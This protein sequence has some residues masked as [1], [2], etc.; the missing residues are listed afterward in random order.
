MID[1]MKKTDT[2]V[3]AYAEPAAGPGWANS[4]VW[5][6]VRDERHV[7]REVCL[8]PQDQSREMRLF[9]SMSSNVNGM[10]VKFVEDLR[11]EK[12]QKT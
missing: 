11:R 7:L 10:M 3:C 9:Y 6:I 2:V 8:Q 12:R 5:V 1:G 4:P